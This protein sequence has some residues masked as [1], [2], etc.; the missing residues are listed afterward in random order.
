MKKTKLDGVSAIIGFSVNPEIRAT[1][2]RM[3][4]DEKAPLLGLTCHLGGTSSNVAHALS[5]MGLQSKLYAMTGYNDDFNTHCFKFALEH[6]PE[7][8]I[9]ADFNILEQGHMGFIP[10]DGIKKTSQVFGLKGLIQSDKISDCLGILKSETSPRVWRIA[11]GVR[12][13]EVSLVKALFNGN[14][15]FRYLN[16]RMDLIIEKEIFFDLLGQTDILVVNQKE[17]DACT[18]Y[19]ELNSMADIQEK[20]GVSLVIVTKD[21]DGGKFSLTNPVTRVRG[22]FEACTHYLKKGE[23]IF[24]T[25]TGDWFGGSFMSIIIKLEKSIYE[26]NENE[27]NQAINFARLVAGKKVT[28]EGPGNGPKESDL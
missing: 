7:N 17:F 13:A 18:N 6:S 4:E 16:P 8:I 9:G 23:E 15:G 14:V 26:I 21:K 28:M 5:N 20:F 22:K 19:Q 1:Y 10:S 24:P 25:G 3:T 2:D 12:P 11:T 27:I